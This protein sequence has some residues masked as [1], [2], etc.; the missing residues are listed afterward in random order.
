MAAWIG[1]GY[2]EHFA[3]LGP[4]IGKLMAATSGGALPAVRRSGQRGPAGL[5]EQVNE[6]SVS[7]PASASAPSVIF[8]VLLALYAAFGLC[9]GNA[10]MQ[11]LPN[12]ITRL[13]IIADLIFSHGGDFGDRFI[14]QPAFSPYIA[15][16]L[17]LATLDRF[18]STAWACRLCIAASIVLLPLSVWFVVRQQGGSRVAA[19]AAGVLA[20]YVATDSMFTMGF[21]NFLLSA[22]CALFAYGW[23]CKATRTPSGY[24]YACFALLLLLS[25]AL[26]LSALI[27]SIT[28]AAVSAAL[29][30]W[31]K[32]LSIKRAAALLLPPLSLLLLQIALSPGTNLHAVYGWGTWASKLRWLAFPA[33]RFELAT[34]MPILVA[35]AAAAAFPI[36]VSWRRGATAGTEQ[37]LIAGALAF[38]YVIAP[39]E[40]GVTAYLDV[41]ALHY[42][43]LFLLCAG[44]RCAELHPRVQSTQ[45]AAAAIIAVMN[46]VYLA[47]WMLPQN[48][49]LGD[50]R[51]LAARIPADA[52]VLPID[53]RAPVRA[54]HYYDPWRHAGAYVTLE[55]RALTPYLFAGDRQP[56]LSYFR[57]TN[58]P[59]APPQDWYFGGDPVHWERVMREYPYL[60]VTVPWDARKIPAAY[61][62][63][64]QNDVAALLELREK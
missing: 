18:L 64:A 1:R 61:T 62:V 57:Y 21:A 53:T 9:L 63:V 2:R 52:N 24:S 31:Q 55:S 46:L 34:D 58:R 51:A 33:W 54:H 59:Y 16:D 38:L 49:A 47:A 42:A 6:C 32:R 10:P 45:L 26:H 14:F 22:A 43:W 23:F 11:D 29:W 20:L 17:L 27:F 7:A 37:L 56:H 40:V 35:F 5:A 50:Y 3:S 28:I 48:A 36:A 60:L 4:V 25:Y 30:V 19:G 13:H 39:G 15:G 12:H 41:R 44:V 8:L